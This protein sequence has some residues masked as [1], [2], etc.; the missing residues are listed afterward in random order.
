ME[1]IGDF[2]T[3]WTKLINIK[4]NQTEITPTKSARSLKV[5]CATGH[6]AN[7]HSDWC[8]NELTALALGSTRLIDENEYIVLDIGSRDLKLVHMK[9]NK[10]FKMDWNS[11]CGSLTGF[12]LELMG[13]Y[14]NLDFSKIE[15]SKRSIPISC[16]LIGIEKLFDLIAGGIPEDEAIARFTHGLA[17]SAHSFCGNPHRLYLSG[18][19]CS[20]DLFIKSFPSSVELISLGRYVLLEGLKQ[21]INENNKLPLKLTRF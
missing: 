19:M 11:T 4:N 1:Y 18:G 21:E 10:P 13:N 17:L 14:Y 15:P 8:I 3:T 20:N 16:G 12:T 6:N 5:L 9:N 7:L 2:G